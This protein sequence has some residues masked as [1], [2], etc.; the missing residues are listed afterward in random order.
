MLCYA[1]D[2][3]WVRS[4][5]TIFC[6]GNQVIAML[7]DRVTLK[8]SFGLTLLTLLVLFSLGNM[9]AA[10]SHA[11]TPVTVRVVG[12]AAPVQ[13][14]ATF[15]VSIT[16]ENAQNLGAFEFEYRY[17]NTVVSTNAQAIQLGSLLGSTGRT[18]GALRLA[19][20]PGFPGVPLFG[21]YSYGSVNGPNGNG[22]LAT[23]TMTAV[24]PGTSTLNL[25]NLKIINITGTEV[26]FNAVSSSVIVAGV[27]PDSFLYLP[28]LRH[29]AP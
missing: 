27:P 1:C 7:P 12:P 5:E 23:V 9:T 10:I 4:L 17:D 6:K 18:T 3:M 16:I 19:S 24:A 21:A 22:T 20:A 13:V 11:Q 29:N 25:G 8:K 14:G 15:P 26:T 28:I 2:L